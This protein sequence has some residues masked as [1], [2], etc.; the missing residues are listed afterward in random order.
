MPAVILFAM[1]IYL[2]RHGQTAWNAG[3]WVQGRYDV[4]LN[5]TGRQQ[6]RKAGLE[7][8]DVP[9]VK[10]YCSPAIR[11]Q[12]T[13]HLALEGRDV[14]IVLDERLVEMAYGIYENTNWR[15]GDYQ[16]LRRRLAYRYPNG[17]SYF[18][19]AHR[20]FS[21]LESIMDEAEKGD[22]LLV[23]HGGIGRAINAYFVDD[24]TNDSFIDTICPN[25]GIKKYE[26]R[27]HFI[28]PVVPLPEDHH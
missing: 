11:A 23:C 6:A 15:D 24:N 7:L 4:P 18:D 1:S 19:V 8:K 9:F 16:E 10:C 26:P 20:A 28:P 12:E 17:E 14:P 22:I 13:A 5:D 21:F 2:L 27:R 3:G 25:G